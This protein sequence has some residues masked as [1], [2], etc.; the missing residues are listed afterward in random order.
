MISAQ[1][2]DDPLVRILELIF[3]SNVVDVERSN[4]DDGVVRHF[5]T[6]NSGSNF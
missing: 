5:G 2:L 4:A 1:P 3:W 6:G